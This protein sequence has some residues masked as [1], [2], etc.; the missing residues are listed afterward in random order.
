MFFPLVRQQQNYY[1]NTN[2]RTGCWR[3]NTR[4]TKTELSLHLNQGFFFLSSLFFFLFLSKCLFSSLLISTLYLPVNFFGSLFFL[5]FLFFF[6]L[7]LFHS[8]YHYCYCYKLDNTKLQKI[9]QEILHTESE[10]KQNHERA[11]STKPQEKKGKKV[12]SNTDSA[13]HNQILND[14]RQL[15]D[16]NHH[17]PI[18][19]N[20][21][22]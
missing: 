18:N 9:L 6:F 21:E 19:T 20:T 4:T 7:L 12:E 22:C 8:R 13:A 15:Q 10:S 3:S 5:I 11:G 16:R 1:S 14:Q 17:I 2:T